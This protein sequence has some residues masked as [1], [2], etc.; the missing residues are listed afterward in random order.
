MAFLTM[1]CSYDLAKSQ[2]NQKVYEQTVASKT[3]EAITS[4]ISDVEA[5]SSSKTDLAKNSDYKDLV[6]YQMAYDTKVESLDT[7]IEVL[8]QEMQSFKEA[9]KEGIKQSTSFWCFG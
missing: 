5:L 6:A 3:L 2:Y 8:K 7:E 9:M 1:K 4:K